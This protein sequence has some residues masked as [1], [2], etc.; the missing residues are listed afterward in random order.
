MANAGFTPRQEGRPA[1]IFETGH[2]ALT[3]PRKGIRE[4]LFDV[5]DR[6][7]ASAL[8]GHGELSSFVLV[9]QAPGQCGRPVQILRVTERTPAIQSPVPRACSAPPI[10]LLT[11]SGVFAFQTVATA[12]YPRAI[13]PFGPAPVL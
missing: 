5:P 13:H 12:L 8:C 7:V 11:G 6:L 3:R 4:K 1:E 2:R 10:F 9:V